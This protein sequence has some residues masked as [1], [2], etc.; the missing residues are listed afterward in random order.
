MTRLLAAGHRGLLVEC[1]DLPQVMA[2]HRTLEEARAGGALPGVVD[3]VPA[4]RTV[5]VTFDDTS[6][7]SRVAEA[8]AS[9]DVRPADDER[10]DRE[11]EV[12][13][14]YDGDDLHEVARLSGLAVEEVVRRHGAATYRVAFTGF[15]PGFA[16]L[17]GGDAAL[18]VPRRDTPRTRVPRGSVALA[19]EFTGIYPQEGPGGWQLIGRT[20]APLWDLDRQPPALLA[21]GTRVRFTRRD[22]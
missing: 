5:L 22:P 13:V 2:L 6:S 9:L 1:D 4:A 19:G 7:H 21:P 15:A 8:L 10:L 17:V 11:V 14:T 20:E 16:Y 18:V 12:A 3:L